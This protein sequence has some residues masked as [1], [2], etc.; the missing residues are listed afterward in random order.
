MK[1]IE[2]IHSVT[3]GATFRR[4][5]LHMHSF[6]EY[7]SYDVSDSEMH[8]TNIVD[9]ALK[10][11]L[12][13]ISI[14]DHNSIGNIPTALEYSKELPIIVIPGV[15]LST[16]Q[17]HL[18]VYFKDF[19]SLEAFFGKLHISQDKKTCDETIPQCLST[20]KAYGGIG[21]AAH[22]DSA[23]GFDEQALPAFKNE[24]ITAENLLALEI[25]SKENESWYSD[26]DPNSGRKTLHLSRRTD[27]SEDD[28]YEIAKVLFSDAH[29]IDLLGRNASGDKRI[30]RLKMDELSFESFQIALIDA[31]ARVRIEDLI[32]K[33]VPHFVGIKF[34]GGLLDGQ[35][36]KFSNNL[37]CI[38]GGR[39][40]GK[41][42]LVESLRSA[43]GNIANEKLLDSEV[44][45]DRIHLVWEDE[46]GRQQVL[47]KDKLSDVENSTD[48]ETGLT[49]IPIES[50]GQGETA[51]TLQNCGKEPG[52][53]LSFLD[54]FMKFGTLKSEDEEIRNELLKNQTIIEQLNIEVGNIPN[55]KKA[56]T[57]VNA[58]LKA[59]REQ[60][61]NEIIELEEGLAKEQSFKK[62]LKKN[63]LELIDSIGTSLSDTLIDDLMLEIDGSSLVIGKDELKKVKGL[64]GELSKDIGVVSASLKKKTDSIVSRIDIQLQ[65]WQKKESDAQSKIEEIRKAL[66]KQGVKLDMAFIKKTTTDAVVYTNK[67]GELQKKKKE[68]WLAIKERSEL[69]SR[70]R[71]L[72]STIYSVRNGFA[73][74]MNKNLDETV[75]EYRVTIKFR[76]GVLSSECKQIIQDA[77]G[78]RTSQ[79]PKADIISS[80]IPVTVLID[81]IKK[82]N[83]ALIDTIKLNKV[84]VFTPADSKSIINTLSEHKNLFKLE[85]C[86]FEDRPEI[87][88][89]KEIETPEGDKKHVIRE[90]AKLSLGQQQS[91]ILSILLFSKNS[92][93]LI[94][95]QPEDNLDSEFI[96]K[97]IVRNL[98]SIKEIRQVIIATHNA[99]IAV[100]GDAELIIPL[101]ST[102]DQASIHDRGSIDEHGTKKITC[103]ILEGSDKA[104]IKRKKIYGI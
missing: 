21:I 43:S 9:V 75:N 36:V 93:P 96:Y 44:W 17:G 11:G 25:T 8:P 98:R 70:R 68:L 85:R 88:I 26:R 40:T 82:K 19:A 39:G 12:E 100:L 47:Y 30:T 101:K 52:E 50:Y 7:G 2:N 48:P 27:I 72:K 65:S 3:Y 73:I 58:Q 69:V 77:L 102:S 62:L 35:V 29:S 54:R 1:I 45:P 74:S 67:L 10:E 14:T 6:G 60:N 41:S 20:A 87:T 22:I 46:T 83:Y 15:E 63:L 79:V 81:A 38:I 49:Y 59:L 16:P 42:T 86:E 97:T 28:G 90:F 24:I 78:W 103:T 95:D 18:L 56:L 61:A 57:N 33:A 94:I 32:P 84:K 64:L 23:A 71:T 66:L 31:M 53:L 13:V 99:N 37:T 4:A 80:L 51:K 5:D 91:I 34:D 104:F 76:E 92:Y 55:I 89:A